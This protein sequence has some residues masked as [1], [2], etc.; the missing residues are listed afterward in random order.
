MSRRRGSL[1]YYGPDQQ[2]LLVDGISRDF[3]CFRSAGYARWWAAKKG[4]E[5]VDASDPADYRLPGQPPN[6]RPAFASPAFSMIG[7]AGQEKAASEAS[8][9]S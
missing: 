7:V 4:I 6:P 2:R 8:R 5:F 3:P 9:Y 1:F